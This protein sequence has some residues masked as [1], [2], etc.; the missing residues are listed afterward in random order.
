MAK[1]NIHHAIELY[2]E[3]EE[4]SKE[5][6]TDLA[7]FLLPCT[8]KSLYDLIESTCEIQNERLPSKERKHPECSS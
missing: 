4:R 5:S 6:H 7:A 8:K 2:A 3:A 1:K